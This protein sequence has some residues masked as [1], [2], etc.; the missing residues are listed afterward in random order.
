M[1][2]TQVNNTSDQKKIPKQNK[3]CR[4]RSKEMEMDSANSIKNFFKH[5]DKKDMSASTPISAKKRSPPNAKKLQA[6]RMNSNINRQPTTQRK[7]K[8][9]I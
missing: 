1:E 5:E 7:M 3:K 2:T 8:R 6:K 4:K 9:N